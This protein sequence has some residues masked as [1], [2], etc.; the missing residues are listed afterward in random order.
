MKWNWTS[1]AIFPFASVVIL[2]ATALFVLYKRQE[3][4]GR[5]FGVLMLLGCAEFMMC[6]VFE[7]AAPTLS[8]KIFWNKTEYLGFLIAPTAWLIYALRYSGRE[9]WLRPRTYIILSVLPAVFLG[10]VFTNELHEL[11]WHDV[12]LGVGGLFGPLSKTYGVGFWIFVAYINLTLLLA[13]SLYLEMLIRSGQL[14]RWQTFALVPATVFAWL[15]I[16]LDLFGVSP[17]PKLVATAI[18]LI[19][20]GTTVAISLSQLQRGDIL[21][22]SHRALIAGM[23]DG[24]VVLDGRNRV[25]ELNATAQGLLGKSASDV[26]EQPIESV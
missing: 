21:R 7:R 19:A 4:P 18:G 20:G 26:V 6:F 23:G 1:Y 12:A 15:G 16:V 22:V 13:T 9:D 3:R 10:A 24:V 2:I 25:V 8:S 11:F 17:L 14:Y 5:I